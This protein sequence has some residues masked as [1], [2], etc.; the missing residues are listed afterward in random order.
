MATICSIT[1]RGKTE[2]LFEY[3]RDLGPMSARELTQV[4]GRTRRAIWDSLT[5]LRDAKRIY[6]CRY[7]HQEDGVAGRCSPIYKIGNL[8]DCKMPQRKST[9]ERDRKYRLRNKAVLQARQRARRSGEPANVWSG[10]L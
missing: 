4:T 5:L 9:L 8:P 6:I 3:L 10:L 7:E 1:G 2:E